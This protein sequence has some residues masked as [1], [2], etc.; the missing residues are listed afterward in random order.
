MKS[1]SGSYEQSVKLFNWEMNPFNFRILPD[2]FVGYSDELEKLTEVVRSNEK[3]SLLLGPTGSGKTTLLRHILSKFGDSHGTIYLPKPPKNPQDL[4]EILNRFTSKGILCRLFSR[5]N[6]INLY[7]LSENVNKKM[8]KGR[9]IMLV[10]E[11]HESSVDTLE[12]L[13][14]ITDQVDNLGIVLAGLPVLDNVLRENLETFMLRVNMKIEL[15]N[16]TRSETRELIKK[17]I[18]WAGGD[19]VKPFTSEAID[20][21]YEKTSGFPRE[22]I[23]ICNELVKSAVKKNISTIDLNFLKETEAGSAPIRR[24]QMGSIEDLPQ[25]QREILNLIGKKGEMSPSEIVE[26]LD[27]KEYKDKPNAIRSVNNILKRLLKEGMLLRKEKGRSY[28][29]TLSEKIKTFMVN[30]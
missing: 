6:N 16:L 9:I 26:E 12:W 21:I 25:R 19:D 2:L 13:R 8:K 27:V 23:R 1:R 7:N 24:M 28:K 18:E 10:D 15:T 11:S 14:T 22:I 5:K 4:V 3:F 30:A 29:Y 17:R 20:F